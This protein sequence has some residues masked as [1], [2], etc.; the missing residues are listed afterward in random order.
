MIEQAGP[1]KVVR[2]FCVQPR[3]DVPAV[4]RVDYPETGEFSTV[5]AAHYRLLE[6]TFPQVSARTRALLDGEGLPL[7][8]DPIVMTVQRA[9]GFTWKRWVGGKPKP[10]VGVQR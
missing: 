2:F 5:C 8:F 7:G 10:A 6:S 1:V 3:C 4:W 9:G